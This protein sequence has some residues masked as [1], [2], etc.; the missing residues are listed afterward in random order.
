[1][2]SDLVLQNGG[3]IRIAESLREL[4]GKRMVYKGDLDG[5]PVVVKLYLDP[6][7]S[8]V[9]QRREIE[10]VT[11]L[12]NAGIAAP[13]L[14]SS[15][16]DGS[17]RPLVV[18]AYLDGARDLAS[19]WR[20]ADA[21]TRQRLIVDMLILLARQ[22]I[23]GIRQ[24]DLHLANFLALDGRIYTLDGAGITSKG[25]ALDA[26]VGWRNLALFCSQLPPDWDAYCVEQSTQYALITQADSNGLAKALPSLID[27]ARAQRWREQSNKIYRD[28]TAV[29]QIRKPAL[30]G[31]VRRS[32]GPQ[33]L[34]RLDDIDDT[35]PDNPAE[36]LKN[37]N[38]ATVWR[39]K[40]GESS[41]V[42]KRYNVKNWHHALALAMKESRASRSWRFA[43]MLQ[44]YG[45]RTP[46]PVALLYRGPK[47]FGTVAYF[48]AEDI[49]GI[50]LRER[51]ASLDDDADD[52]RALAAQLALMLA[53]LKSI[54][55]THGD[56]KA[57]NF[58]VRE[59][60]LFVIDLDA[61]R[62]HR[63]GPAFERAWRRD[64][65]RLDAN[66]QDR[67]AVQR[68]FRDARRAI[69]GN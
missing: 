50:S 58:I 14:L 48:I 23:A 7:R 44:L 19:V 18:L 13:D 15:G 46:A 69:V 5:V 36:L 4:P 17:G 62:Q 33:L 16:E 53:R 10:G 11:A 21:A 68:M 67:P 32:Y 8:R 25:H 47:R 43:H 26:S 56:M 27:S 55:V 59:D 2:T 38:T 24:T 6:R 64:L 61:M 28:C 63:D 22:H 65:D 12:H 57:T 31:F 9:H 40:L 29:Q 34:A 37:G 30:R 20:S 41:V 52:L 39:T 60:A 42:V 1:M 3:R 49:G 54:R 45:V 51:I 66:W 35:R